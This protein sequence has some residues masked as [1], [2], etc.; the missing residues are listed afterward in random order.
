MLDISENQ[1]EGTHG[2]FMDHVFPL[3]LNK[4]TMPFKCAYGAGIVV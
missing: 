3:F 1:K 4:E 2:S